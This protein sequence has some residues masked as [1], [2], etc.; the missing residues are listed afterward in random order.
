MIDH[1]P[2]E[3]RLGYGI[4]R[5][6]LWIFSSTSA[7]QWFPNGLLRCKLL[8][9]PGAEIHKLGERELHIS[10]KEQS[11]R[12]NVLGFSPVEVTFRD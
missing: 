5:Y 1:F 4:L 7:E 10:F 8:Y 3:A 11:W 6:T 2:T 9:S 12:Q